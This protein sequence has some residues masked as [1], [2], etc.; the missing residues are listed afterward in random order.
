MVCGRNWTVSNCLFIWCRCLNIVRCVNNMAPDP[1]R[2]VTAR[3]WVQQEYAGPDATFVKFRIIKA[4]GAIRRH[5]KQDHF[6]P[7]ITWLHSF[8]AK[9]NTQQ[10][11]QQPVTESSR[12]W[13]HCSVLLCSCTAKQKQHNDRLRWINKEIIALGY[14]FIPPGGEAR[15]SGFSGMASFTRRDLSSCQ[16]ASVSG[17]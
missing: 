7:L 4:S 11:K 13:S 6:Y 17:R 9:W 12:N 2:I 3:D 16:V 5:M 10:A 15:L 8:K 14:E 1:S